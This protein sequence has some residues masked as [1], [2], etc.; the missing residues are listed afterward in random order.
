MFE[1]NF[2]TLGVIDYPYN[3]VSWPIMSKKM[4]DTLLAVGTFP[5]RV[6]PV[7]MIDDTVMTPDRYDEAGNPK[8]GVG[9]DRFVAI[10]L[11]E[12]LDVFDWEQS[13]YERHERFPEYVTFVEKLALKTRPGGFPPLF[14]I[15]HYPARLF[16]S[17]EARLAL[18]KAGIQGLEFVSLADFRG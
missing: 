11:L 17:A 14:Y 8:P 7:I 6:I 9:T 18:E 13:V 5:H 1:A 3:D 15:A 12:E 16:V 10:Q 4:L 2:R